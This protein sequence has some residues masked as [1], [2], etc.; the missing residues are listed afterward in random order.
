M[1]SVFQNIIFYSCIIFLFGA[2]LFYIIKLLN[3][4]Q[5]L[6]RGPKSNSR[7]TTPDPS[8]NEHDKLLLDQEL[9]L[10][11]SERTR[12]AQDLHDDLAQDLTGLRVNL[13]L[14]NL[15]PY[16]SEQS[17]SA[18]TRMNIQIDRIF[19]SVKNTI[20][21]LSPFTDEA[22]G[23]NDLV[24]DLCKR[25][26][27]LRI[28]H[29]NFASV[30]NI[31]RLEVKQVQG[32]FRIIQESIN[33]SVKHSL[34]WR[35]NVSFMWHQEEIIIKIIDE[36]IG[37]ERARAYRDQ[38]DLGSTGLINLKKRAALLNASLTIEDHE[39]KGTAVIIRMP[40]N[41]NIG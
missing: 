9:N 20:W 5:Q 18:T 11:E 37:R 32:L 14:I 4:L 12:I 25:T 33:N 30:G 24:N 39:P 2:L 29:V 22:K 28:A 21:N 7:E 19:S 10:L 38:K 36:G 16:L 23:L 6:K 34:T 3:D 1:G 35:I 27:N 31:I 41:R 17:R 40:I 26:N 15:E 13:E 8:L